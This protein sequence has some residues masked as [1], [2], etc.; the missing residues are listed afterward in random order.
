ML[1][2]FLSNILS[3][4]KTHTMILACAA[5]DFRKFR[6]IRKTIIFLKFI[7]NLSQAK[8]QVFS[9]LFFSSRLGM[10]AITCT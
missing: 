5:D 9:V 2:D 1:H 7:K 6:K 4:N 8:C 3:S 10:F